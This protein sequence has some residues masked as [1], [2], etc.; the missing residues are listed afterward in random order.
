[1]KTPIAIGKQT[2][3][4]GAIEEFPLQLALEFGGEIKGFGSDQFPTEATKKTQM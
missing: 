4:D 3:R 1:V 2:W